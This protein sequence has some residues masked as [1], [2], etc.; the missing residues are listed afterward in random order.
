[1]NNEKALQQFKRSSIGLLVTLAITIV[2]PAYA[3]SLNCDEVNASGIFNVLKLIRAE[4]RT[5]TLPVVM[6][7]SSD[8]HHDIKAAYDGGVN[9]F[10]SKPV[11]IVDFTRA[12]KELGLYWMI[13]N[14]TA[15]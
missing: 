9:S 13:I 4:E 15:P 10:I 11:N 8:E 7:T 3:T 6:L 2:N 1:L 12:V 5:T 14:K